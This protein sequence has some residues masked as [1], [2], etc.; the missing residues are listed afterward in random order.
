MS[1]IKNGSLYLVLSEEYGDGKKALDVAGPAVA[2]GI[3]ILQMREKYRSREELLR[4]GADLAALCRRNGVIFIVND[5]PVLAG[6]VGADGVHL[7]QEDLI[8]FS[9]PAA[10]ALLGPGKI[11][12]ISTHSLRQVE[13]A[14]ALDPDYIAYGPIFP[15]ETKDYCIGV[16]DVRKVLRIASRPVVFIGGINR[17]NL[18]VLL[19]EGARNIALIRD[20]M[21]AEDIAARAAWY[22]ERL[23]IP[24]HEF[25]IPGGKQRTREN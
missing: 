22:K 9:V 1:T 3:D 5:D 17:S 19:A 15:T 12:G 25:Q 14:R 6:D 21:R 11:V 20:I 24:N 10:R 4:L 2:G 18:D 13:E 23:K 8:R 7:G 16:G